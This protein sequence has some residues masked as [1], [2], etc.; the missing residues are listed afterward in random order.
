MKVVCSH[1]SE[2][3]LRKIRITLHVETLGDISREEYETEAK[4]LEKEQITQ[5]RS[6]V[7]LE[8]VDLPSQNT[9]FCLVNC[10][11][12]RGPDYPGFSPPSP[13]F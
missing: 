5:V 7:G 1:L 2:I 10:I 8:Q 11:L 4:R 3:L 13:T 9:S 12:L 6:H